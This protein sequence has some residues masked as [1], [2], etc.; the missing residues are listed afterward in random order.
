MPHVDM[1]AWF[2]TLRDALAAPRSRRYT[3]ITSA[4]R[5]AAERVRH[6]LRSRIL[7]RVLCREAAGDLAGYERVRFQMAVVIIGRVTSVSEP[8]NSDGR[9]RGYRKRLGCGR[10]LWG[11]RCVFLRCPDGSTTA[12]RHGLRPGRTGGLSDPEPSV[13]VGEA[14][15]VRRGAAERTFGRERGRQQ[16]PAVS[17][18]RCIAEI[19]VSG[20]FWPEIDGGL[21][22]RR[23]ISVLAALKIG[24]ATDASTRP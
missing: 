6:R 9:R 12:R 23:P 17:P 22:L 15:S 2:G 5:S 19:G 20:Q 1:P 24:S 10:G 8:A 21:A 7:G 11:V 16:R 14:D 18:A 3:C 4:L 13:A